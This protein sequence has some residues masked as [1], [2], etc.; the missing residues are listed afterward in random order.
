MRQELTNVDRDELEEAV[1]NKH[2]HINQEVLEKIT[3]VPLTSE[4]IKELIKDY[5]KGEFPGYGPV[6]EDPD[7]ELIEDEITEEDEIDEEEIEDEVVEDKGEEEDTSLELP[8]DEI[9]AEEEVKEP[10]LDT[11]D[12]S[13]ELDE[14]IKID[15]TETE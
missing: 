8:E 10:E 13:L 14:E 9:I 7:D 4:Q 2:K 11:G 6:E 3:E 12:T 15:S 5:I 1:R